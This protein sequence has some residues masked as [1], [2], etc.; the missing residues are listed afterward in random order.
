MSVEGKVIDGKYKIIE[1]VGEGGMSYVYLARDKRL[2]KQWA[3]KQI[4]YKKNTNRK[5]VYSTFIKEANLLK[6]L[7]HPL[8]PRIVDI[9]KEDNDNI[10]VIMDYIEGITLS[11]ALELYGLQSQ[12]TIVSW[13]IQICDVLAYLH[14]RKKPIIFR[15]LK[16]SNIMLTPEGKIK[17]IDFGT[18]IEYTE[19]QDNE[20]CL[21]TPGYAPPEQFKESKEKVDNRSDIFAF[22]KTL[23]HLLTGKKP[24]KGEDIS[25]RSVNSELSDGLEKIIDKC[26]KN[27]PYERYQNIDEVLYDLKHYKELEVKF[28]KKQISRIIYFIVSV[29]LSMMFF[30]TSL[31]GVMAQ[32][33]K[34]N[35][36]YNLLLSEASTEVSSSI[37]NDSFS[38][39][40][41]DTYEKAIELDP[42]R[43]EAYLK[44][45][46]YYIRMKQTEIGL[47]KVET[48]I[49]RKNGIEKNNDVLL[50]IANLYFNGNTA[51]I[52]FNV[53]Y[54]KAAKYYSMI[55][56][57]KVVYAKYYKE[58][59]ITLSQFGVSIDWNNVC[60]I[61]QEFEDYID[62]QN[63]D[64]KQIENYIAMAKLYLCNKTYINGCGVDS[65]EVVIN[66]LEKAKDTMDFLDDKDIIEKFQ[67]SIYTTLAETF[68]LKA[69]KSSDNSDYASALEYYDLAMQNAFSDDK[70][71]DIL[72]KEADIYRSMKNY[73]EASLKYEY[74]INN[75]PYSIEAYASYGMMEITEM[76]NLDKAKELYNIATKIKD[77]DK[78]ANLH[79]LY[80]KI[81]N[82]G[83]L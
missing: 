11:E 61:L 24:K 36:D 78:N 57:K 23:F 6:N 53:D 30:L 73:T 50:S 15:D 80:Q 77:A 82:S 28:R 63:K 35:N 49:Q 25:I 10:Y 34:I 65:F 43:S 21:G 27:N 56:E 32:K 48:Y 44:V 5:V 39:E 54:S 83:R 7:D 62:S 13:G 59:S 12:E 81:K 42:E 67:D 55:D 3:V 72:C 26:T 64:S 70:K 66:C 37:A 33:K 51:D 38:E 4:K 18:A 19:G 16:P 29:F 9:I 46:D 14:S 20:I 52:D 8:L 76:Q 75:Y 45:I 60:N 68:H 31:F 2:N 58:L 41:I 40:V 47:D 1:L 79:A 17:V 71:I 69:A 22:G 74:I